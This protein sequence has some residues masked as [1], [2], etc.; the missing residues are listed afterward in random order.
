[1]TDHKKK[2]LSIW[3]I[4]LVLH[5]YLLCFRL[6]WPA[7]IVLAVTAVSLLLMNFC[8]DKYEYE[9]TYYTTG[10]LIGATLFVQ[11]G[12][13]AV[14]HILPVILIQE[15][16]LYFFA[17]GTWTGLVSL[18]MDVCA[19]P[20]PILTLVLPL[21]CSAAFL[22]MRIAAR[23]SDLGSMLLSYVSSAIA[24]LTL[25]HA[26]SGT[27]MQTMLLM[28][29]LLMFFFADLGP[30]LEDN[31][32]V[33]NSKRW[34][35]SLTVCLIF[36]LA[37]DRDALQPLSNV[38]FLERHFVLNATRWYH[39]AAVTV[40]LVAALIVHAEFD[41]GDSSNWYDIK[42]ALYGLSTLYLVLILRLFYVGY[43][44][45][46]M[47]IHM[48]Y[49]FFDQTFWNPTSYDEDDYIKTLLIQLGI[50][51]AC[52]LLAVIGH[53]G[54]LLMILAVAAGLFLA[55][56]ALGC[57]VY[58]ELEKNRLPL[59]F[60]LLILAVLV[61][62]LAWLWVYRRLL[63]SFLVALFLAAVCIGIVWLYSY[64]ND[65]DDSRQ[66][67]PCFLVVL[68]FI[69]G[70]LSLCFTGGSRIHVELGEQGYPVV[71]T[72]ARGADNRVMS[73]VYHWTED[74]LDLD[75]PGLSVNSSREQ[76]SLS[77]LIGHEGKL[78]IVVTDQ[79]GITTETVFWLHNTPDPEE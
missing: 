56:T 64:G 35:T 32:W 45:I 50:S 49:L 77:A 42:Y 52:G 8:W 40:A 53:F 60:T 44:W 6:S 73:V 11:L 10:N 13:Y 51:A 3:I 28:L 65:A 48:L 14:E 69:V 43:W 61:P 34:I 26:L 41:T 36:L 58:E 18:V 47:G 17:M 19:V 25:N 12:W 30:V 1:M 39:M 59:F 22:A 72:E 70:A 63:H 2:H 62:T 78:R 4:W 33:K 24:L 74:W 55:F 29:V 5:A 23:E 54:I 20:S 66:Y 67:P 9:H 79:F 27:P 37:W 38:D 21:L 75:Q 16:P 76:Q 7:L 71:D 15:Q 57:L 46:L 68:I 31:E